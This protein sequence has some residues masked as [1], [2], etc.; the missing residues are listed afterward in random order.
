MSVTTG[1]QIGL[2]ITNLL[3]PL[4]NTLGRLC[5]LALVDALKRSGSD[6]ITETKL[7]ALLG[8]HRID[9]TLKAHFKT[10]VSSSS[11]LIISRYIDIALQSGAGPTVQE[12]LKD[13]EVALF[14]MIVQLSLLSFACSDQNL[15]YAISTAVESLLDSQGYPMERAPDYVSLSGTIRVCR[16]QTAAFRWN[17]HYEAVEHKIRES[18]VSETQP[19]RLKNGSRKKRKL[20]HWDVLDS[21]YFMDRSIPYHALK[22]LIMWIHSIQNFPEERHLHIQCSTGLSTIIIWCHYVLGLSVTVW[23]ANREITFGEGTSEITIQAVHPKE[24]TSVLYDAKDRSEALFSLSPSVDDPPIESE[25]RIEAFGFARKYLERRVDDEASIKDFAYYITNIALLHLEGQQKTAEDSFPGFQ[26]DLPSQD[27]VFRAARFL[28]AADIS[29]EGMHNDCTS[30][31]RTV[32]TKL[33]PALGYAGDSSFVILLEAFSRLHDIMECQNLPLSLYEFRDLVVDSQRSKPTYVFTSLAKSFDVL[34]RLIIGESFGFSRDDI[35]RSVLI[36][37]WGWSLFLGCFNAVDPCDVDAT[38]FY[39][40]PGVPTR[41]GVRKTRIVDALTRQGRVIIASRKGKIIDKDAGVTFFEGIS[42]AGRDRILIGNVDERTFSVAQSFEWT[43][44]NS[45]VE[46]TYRLGLR[47]MLELRIQ[48]AMLGACDCDES[49]EMFSLSPGDNVGYFDAGLLWGRF[50]FG[51]PEFDRILPVLYQQIGKDNKVDESV[52]RSNISQPITYVSNNKR[53]PPGCLLPSPVVEKRQKPEDIWCYN[54]TRNE[55]ARWLQLSD[56]LT[57]S[58]Q[59]VT[60][61]ASFVLV[62]RKCCYQHAVAR[63]PKNVSSE[64]ERMILVLL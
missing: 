24:D 37:A 31:S 32:R 46:C 51:L 43:P 56:F 52:L 54:V 28:F 35:D 42:T 18:L 39:A 2:E 6:I 25:F 13:D 3:A 9:P 34:S 20:D 33:R 40:R 11:E 38:Y 26:H 41:R 5:N 49:A 19:T 21:N 61:P 29:A 36:S 1:F 8:R 62:H 45:K 63:I 48:A 10:S 44:L 55:A 17:Y 22:A 58:T 15:A 64:A 57:I 27:D 59:E 50:V 16:Q 7:A 47:E 53:V 4:G 12:A 60:K 23:I 14:S 30:L